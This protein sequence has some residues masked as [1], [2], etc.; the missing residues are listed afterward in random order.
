MANRPIFIP[1]VEAPFFSVENIEFTWNKGLA[2]CQ[3]K[4]NIRAI[5]DGF[6]QL[7]P[8]KTALEISTKSLQPEGVP[9]SAFRLKLD[10]IEVEKR[11]HA[12]KVVNHNGSPAGPFPDLAV[13]DL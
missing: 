2:I 4:K 6:S 7:N 11:Y 10:G 8:G 9:L 5:H 12:A 1:C 13:Q 3:K